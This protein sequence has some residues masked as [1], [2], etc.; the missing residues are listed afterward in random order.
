MVAP[1]TFPPRV[2]EG[3]LFSKPS[4][5]FII[6]RFFDGGHSD[7]YGVI[8]HCSTDLHFSNNERCWASF[9]V[10]IDHL[11][12]SPWGYKESDKSLVTNTLRACLFWRNVCLGLFPSFWLGC[13]FFLQLKI[14]NFEKWMLFV[15]RKIWRKIAVSKTNKSNSTFTTHPGFH[16]HIQLILF[17][18]NGTSLLMAALNIYHT[19]SSIIVRAC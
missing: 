19:I 5:A 17:S 1:I 10:F 13:L 14:N 4:P 3:S 15:T 9:H 11:G 18:L 2:Q 6:C 16:L 12:H 8:S 7:Q